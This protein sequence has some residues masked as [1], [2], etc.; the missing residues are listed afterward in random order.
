MSEHYIAIYAL[1]EP[2]TCEIRYVGKTNNLQKRLNGHLCANEMSSLPSQKWIFALGKMGREPLMFI[3][4]WSKDWEEAER[5]WISNFREDGANLLNIAP[6][7][8]GGWSDEERKFG[9]HKKYKSVI[10]TLSQRSK[11]LPKSS[12]ETFRELMT[13]IGNARKEVMDELGEDAVFDFDD[14]VYSDIVMRDPKSF[15]VFN[16]V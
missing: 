14:C 9:D 8:A 16:D 5:R 4:E 13:R 11:G 12:R 1:C 15:R 6:G 2:D 7:G 10:M 3:L